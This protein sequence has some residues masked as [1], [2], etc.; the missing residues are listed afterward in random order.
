MTSLDRD[1]LVASAQDFARRALTAYIDDDS[2]VILI[3]AAFSLEHLCKAY[4]CDKHPALLMEIRNG[5]FDSLLHLTGLGASARKL[6]EPRTISAREALQR[7]EQ[8]MAVRTPRVLLEQLI[9]VRDGI[10]HAGYLSPANTRANLTAFLR[11]SNELYDEMK[12]VEASRWSEHAEL[13]ESLIRDSLTEI[14]HEVQRKIAAA[15]QRLV[16][17]MSMVPVDQQSALDAARQ[18]LM[19]TSYTFFKPNYKFIDYPIAQLSARCPACDHSEAALWG[20]ME[21]GFESLQSISPIPLSSEGLDEK[22]HFLPEAFF[23]ASCELRFDSPDELEAVGFS[24]I[25]II[26]PDWERVWDVQGPTAG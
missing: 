12:V 5:Q 14:D 9:D 15:K 1:Q 13:A 8:L 7:V 18:A 3:N 25:E 20:R 10:V 11:F 16:Q 2:R 21:W 17:V 24:T 4:L 19:P 26:T 23:C 22:S 6:K